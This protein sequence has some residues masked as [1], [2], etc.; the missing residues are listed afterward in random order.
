D[1]ATLQGPSGSEEAIRKRIGELVQPYAEVRVDAL[2]N[3]HATIRPAA[4]SVGGSG[5]ESAGSSTGSPAD[6]STGSSAGTTRRIMLAAHMDEIG[7][8]A[9]HI[10]DEGFVRVRPIGGV[11]PTM[12][13]G[14]R[15]RFTNGIV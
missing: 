3:L 6:G 9:I 15:V 13:L 8:I 12:L 5:A 10:D 1:L 11:S 14:Q 2:G 4:G 7:V